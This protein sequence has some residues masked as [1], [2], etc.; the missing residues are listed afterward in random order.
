MVSCTKKQGNGPENG[1]KKKPRNSGNFR[2][3]TSA[4]LS[5][6]RAAQSHR[7]TIEKGKQKDSVEKG[8]T[9]VYQNSY[10]LH[11]FSQKVET[12]PCFVGEVSHHSE[13]NV[14]QGGPKNGWNFLND[15]RTQRLHVDHTENLGFTPSDTGPG[16]T[17]RNSPIECAATPSA[18]ASGPSGCREGSGCLH[19]M[20]S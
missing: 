12:S 16:S 1:Q 15:P 19:K 9:K 17:T 11:N 2:M 13:K 6:R 4:G 5:Q 10:C 18:V 8:F 3:S 20:N 14:H 7:R